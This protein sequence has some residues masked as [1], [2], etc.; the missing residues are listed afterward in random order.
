MAE[1]WANASESSIVGDILDTDL[2]ITLPTGEGARFATPAGGDYQVA[3]LRLSVLPGAIFEIIHITDNTADVLTVTRG[4]EGT[5]PFAW[6][7]GTR[8][9]GSPSAQ[10]LVDLAVGG[11]GGEANTTSNEGGG[12][13]LALA[14]VG[15]NLPF[16]SLVAGSNIILT[17]SA[18][19]L[20]IAAAGS[21]GEANTSSNAGAGAGLAKA[22]SGIDL[23]FKSLV[24]GANITL[25]PSADEVEI[26]AAAGGGGGGYGPDEPPST[27]DAMDDEATTDKG[28]GGTGLWA[29]RNQG[30]ATYAYVSG[31]LY[32]T[33]PQSATESL[34]I[35]EQVAPTAP[36]RI[37][38]KLSLTARSQD[39][40]RAF[41]GVLRNSDGKSTQ[42][43]QARIGVASMAVE[44]YSTVTT[45]DSR[46]VLISDGYPW[47]PVYFEIEN[48]ATNLIFRVSGNGVVY[49]QVYTET[50]AAWVTTV[51][52]VIIGAND[53]TNTANGSTLVVDWFRRVA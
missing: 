34:R 26:A 1:V 42:I 8:V 40:S 18:D 33:A 37:R 16:K 4:E 39:F 53:L 28:P 30:S 25:T 36:W 13:G 51:D 15:D 38:A 21:V 19:E 43:N 29:W 48:D 22:K 31:S 6:T 7:H 46:P 11:G 12:E 52:R 3:T 5:T 49:S 2:T 9:I 14:K 45:W 47:R 44:R 20:E 24:A 10:S 17:P 50:I 41:L 32:V 35:F 23:P 27:P